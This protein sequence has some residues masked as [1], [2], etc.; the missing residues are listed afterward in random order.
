MVDRLCEHSY[1][2]NLLGSDSVVFDFGANHGDFSHGLISRFGCRIYA[3]EPLASLRESI[4]ASDRL[5][6]M[7]VAIGATN[8]TAR[9]HVFPTRCASLLDARAQDIDPQFEEVEVV[10]LKTFFAR[11]RVDKV[12]LM[13]VDIEGA[14]VDMFESALDDDLK[15]AGQITVEFHDFIYP[16]LHG[17]VEAIKRRLE[18]LGFWTINFSLDNTDVLFINRVATGVSELRYR[19]LKYLARYKEGGKR[20]LRAWRQRHWGVAIG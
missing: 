11:A 17:R 16:Q 19:K 9:L 1:L 13:K 15:R 7:P 5:N 6:L 10:D 2:P 14:E 12:D 18:A 3:A 20:R 8:G 4:K